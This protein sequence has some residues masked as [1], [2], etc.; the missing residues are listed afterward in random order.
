MSRKENSQHLFKYL[1]VS[2][3]RIY[4][5]VKFIGTEA[6]QYKFFVRNLYGLLHSDS[7]EMQVC[8]SKTVLYLLLK[9]RQLKQKHI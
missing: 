1:K 9:S 3:I 8:N 5:V 2:Y 7:Y 6:F 4:N